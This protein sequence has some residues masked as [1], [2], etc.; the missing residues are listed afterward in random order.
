MKITFAGHSSVF[1]ES[2]N[3]VIFSDPILRN[4]VMGL[5]LKTPTVAPGSLLS[6]IDAVIISH[7]HNDH[8]HIPSLRTLPSKKHAI[9]P[10]NCSKYL[11]KAGFS[12]VKELNWWESETTGDLIITAVPVLHVKGR[13]FSCG[14]TGV[15]SY[16][17]S[18]EEKNILV[19]GDIDFGNYDYFRQ[20][21]ERFHIHAVC[22]PVGGMREVS[23][24]EKR[25]G[26]RNVH[27]DPL[28]AWEIFNILE[29]DILIPVHW[30]SLTVS[31]RGVDEA[32]QRLI[33][34]AGEKKDR[35]RFLKQG[36]SHELEN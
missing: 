3:T 4:R 10:N 19:S 17:I 8:L 35:I 32:P 34:I 9:I 33:E 22:L 15:N 31:K 1:I 6:E 29:A 7:A 28:T 20:I 30:G 18:G 14:K 23:Y 13:Y 16:V 27:I 21:K 26:N 11:K 36:E 24:Y 5:K 2:R 25:R 12:S